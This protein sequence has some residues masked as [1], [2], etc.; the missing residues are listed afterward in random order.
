MLAHNL[1]KIFQ[2]LI[3]DNDMEGIRQKEVVTLDMKI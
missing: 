3:N 2:F 1:W